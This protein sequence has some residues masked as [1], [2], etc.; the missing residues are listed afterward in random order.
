MDPV[1]I[2]AS[3]ITILGALGKLSHGVEKLLSLGHAAESLA[4]L[5]NEVS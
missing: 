2:S 3:M 5:I 1:S 4:E